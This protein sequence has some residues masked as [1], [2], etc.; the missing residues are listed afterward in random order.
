[1]P[2]ICAIFDC[3]KPTDRLGYCSAHY[4]RLWR[5][6]HP[7]SQPA[8]KRHD[9]A[10]QRFGALVAVEQCD[11]SRWLCRCDCGNE[12]RILTGDLRRGSTQSCGERPTHP[13]KQTITY[14][15]AHDRVRAVKGPAKNQS[16]CDCTASA[17]HWSYDHGDT[18]EL[19]EVVSSRGYTYEVP[20]SVDPT[21]YNP[22]CVRCHRIFDRAQLAVTLG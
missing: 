10:G 7:L 13:R 9:L 21:H 14:A 12:K 19:T 22:R 3:A 17:A 2:D 18:N 20:Y 4:M 5:Y 11:G 1:M 8:R 15:G 16:C 6:G